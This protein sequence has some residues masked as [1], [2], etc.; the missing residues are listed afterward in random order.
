MKT[1][2][3]LTAE[4]TQ[5]INSDLVNNMP[6]I[7][8]IEAQ[9]KALKIQKAL[10]HVNNTNSHK[11]DLA[12]LAYHTEKP[13]IDVTCSDGS[14]HKTKIKKYPKLEALKHARATKT[15]D[16]LI[17]ELSV[18]N[19]RFSMYRPDYKSGKETQ[20]IEFADFAEFLEYN[21]IEPKDITL[22]EYL[23]TI[24]KL[25]T[26][27]AELQTAIKAY[28]ATCDQLRAYK[29]N[30]YQLLG[31]SNEHLYTYYPNV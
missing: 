5:L 10:E 25:K 18:E 2:E 21:G 11:R 27:N 3:Q 7:K 26:A 14:F 16:N 24:E 8:E 30:G 13:K 23:E 22:S 9:I 6:K 29:L 28:K 20:Y 15:K 4:K 12:R 31:H 1:I 17:L 19:V